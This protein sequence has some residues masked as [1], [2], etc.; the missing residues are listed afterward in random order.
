MSSWKYLRLLKVLILKKK[1]SKPIYKGKMHVAIDYYF[2]KFGTSQNY[3]ST[4]ISK[5]KLID[6]KPNAY[7]C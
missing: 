6:K 3:W 1:K 2:D 7:H 5:T 4:P